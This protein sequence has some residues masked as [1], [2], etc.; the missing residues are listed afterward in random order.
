MRMFLRWVWRRLGATAR[1]TQRTAGRPA[2]DNITL[3]AAMR[4]A[5]ASLCDDYVA[6][7][8]A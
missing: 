1:Q 8:R 6:L 7:R 4:N 3:A 5:V 2:T